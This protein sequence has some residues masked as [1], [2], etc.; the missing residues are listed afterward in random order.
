MAN[1]V[2]T[3]T[4]MLCTA[5]EPVTKWAICQRE[6]NHEMP[7]RSEWHDGEAMHMTE[8][9]DLSLM[10]KMLKGRRDA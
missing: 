6:A 10:R 8:W 9:Y 7:H 5:I 2:E 4:P 3:P 1:A